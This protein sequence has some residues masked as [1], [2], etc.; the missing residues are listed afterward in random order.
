MKNMKKFR[1]GYYVR[2]LIDQQLRE[3]NDVLVLGSGAV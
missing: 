1:T 3:V 2:N